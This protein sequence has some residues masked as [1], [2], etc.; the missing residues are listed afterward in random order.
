MVTVRRARAVSSRSRDGLECRRVTWPRPAAF[1]TLRG[2][3]GSRA[4]VYGMQPLKWTANPHAH[5]RHNGRRLRSEGA[6]RRADRRRALVL[7]AWSVPVK[8][9]DTRGRS[10]A[11]G[12]S[13]PRLVGSTRRLLP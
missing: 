3:L 2:P 12:G 10:L 9:Q 6:G 11:L 5:R 1:A 4:V 13:T 7:P 8:A